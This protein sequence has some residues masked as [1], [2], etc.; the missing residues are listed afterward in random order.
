MCEE[1]ARATGGAHLRR[2]TPHHHA[3]TIHTQSQSDPTMSHYYITT[4]DLPYSVCVEEECWIRITRTVAMHT[5][6]SREMGYIAI[7]GRV[8]APQSVPLSGILRGEYLS[9]VC[10][11]IRTPILIVPSTSISR[12]I[13]I[14]SVP[15]SGILR[16]LPYLGSKK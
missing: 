14:Q 13:Y 9:A 11:L 3:L 2:S 7:L 1:E 16:A 12:Y 15:L 10:P 8:P 4:H 5:Y 6:S